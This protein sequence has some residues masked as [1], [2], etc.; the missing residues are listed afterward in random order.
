FNQLLNYDNLS[1]ALFGQ[2]QWS[3][4][5]RFRLLPGMRINYD[6]KKVNFDQ[7]AYGGLQTTNA[8]LLVLKQSVLAPQTYAANVGDTN[9]SGRIF[10]ST[11]RS[12]TPMAG[13]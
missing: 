2:L 10:P 3:I 5:S 1:A 9:T 6:E 13:T 8:A 12:R 11:T 7:Q 4:G